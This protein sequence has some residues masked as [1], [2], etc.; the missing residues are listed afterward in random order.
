MELH[1][2]QADSLYRE[3]PSVRKQAIKVKE[4]EAITMDYREVN[5]KRQL[6][7][8]QFTVHV[9]SSSS[10]TFYT[11]DQ[12]IAKKVSKEVASVLYIFFF[13]VL[14]INVREIHIFFDSLILKRFGKVQ[15]IYPIRSQSYM[16]CDKN[17]ALIS[18]KT[19]AETPGDW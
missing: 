18:R 13:E 12:T 14:R 6:S 1:N 9:L 16:E 8:Y 19:P 5:Y 17:V 7:F 15:V 3:K 4:F 2:I 10:S 11:Y